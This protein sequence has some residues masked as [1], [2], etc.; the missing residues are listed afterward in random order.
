MFTQRKIISMLFLLFIIIVSLMFSGFF[1]NFIEGMEGGDEPV[2]NEPVA[3]EQVT[4]EQMYKSL[5]GY[6]ED[7]FKNIITKNPEIKDAL[8]EK[9]KQEATTISSENDITTSQ[10]TGIT[11]EPGNE[12][13][14]GSTEEP[15]NESDTGSTEEPSNESDTGST[16]EPSNE[17]VTGSTE[18]P[19]N[20]SGTGTETFIT[21]LTPS[22]FTS[23][24]SKL[25]PLT[26]SIPLK[27]ETNKVFTRVFEFSNPQ[28]F[29]LKGL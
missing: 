1:Y 25:T 29:D 20:E 5:A 18:E 23:T 19:S 12:S 13:G 6:T 21:R 26:K 24:V 27:P 9:M 7:D 10:E 17:S 15:S 22:V 8:K 3:N 11:E 14:T 16:A 4:D 2:A 28:P